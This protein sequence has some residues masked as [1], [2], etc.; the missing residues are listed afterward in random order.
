[1][2]I[3]VNEPYGW[4]VGVEAGGGGGLFPQS[5]PITSVTAECVLFILQCVCSVGD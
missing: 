3:F 2:V 4:G 5:R 1:M